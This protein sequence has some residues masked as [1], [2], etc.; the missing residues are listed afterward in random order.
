MPAFATEF[1]REEK[2]FSEKER[3]IA[4]LDLN[5][6]EEK[7]DPDEKIEKI[8]EV[9][10]FEL[11][12]KFIAWEKVH[13]QSCYLNYRKRKRKI[14]RIKLSQ[15]FRKHLQSNQHLE[16]RDMALFLT[17]AILH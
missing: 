1:P 12:E 10:P 9:T 8:C 7:K 6:E 2:Y 16:I 4:E 15:K 14:Q 3:T 13:T 11:S 17:T 5:K